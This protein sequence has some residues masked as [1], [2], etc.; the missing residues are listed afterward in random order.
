MV[1]WGVDTV[2]TWVGFGNIWPMLANV[3][4]YLWKKLKDTKAS[5][6]GFVVFYLWIL[7]IYLQISKNNGH[8]VYKFGYL[9]NKITNFRGESPQ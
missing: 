3:G 5:L 6:A 2:S 1:L 8:F 9:C 7:I 4:D